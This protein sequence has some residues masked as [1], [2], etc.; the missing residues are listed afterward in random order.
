MSRMLVVLLMSLFFPA[1]TSAA[2]ELPITYT[3][4]SPLVPADE[5]YDV[6]VYQSE[7][8]TVAR[9]GRA[10]REDFYRKATTGKADWSMPGTWIVG[11][12]TGGRMAKMQNLG[13]TVYVTRELASLEEGKTYRHDTHDEIEWQISDLD[14]AFERGAQDKLV[15]GLAA[16]HFVVSVAY[17]Y[18]Q[19]DHSDGDKKTENVAVERHLWFAEAL[20]FSPVQLLPLQLTNNTFAD[21]APERIHEGIYAR[22]EDQLSAHGMLV[23]T[24]LTLSGMTQT[25]E[26]ANLESVQSLDLTT[27]TGFPIVPEAQSGEV[28]GALFL[29]RMLQGNLPEGGDVQLT[30]N[31]PDSGKKE[32]GA[33]ESAFTVSDDG[34]LGVAATFT[35]DKRDEGLMLIMRPWHGLP[36]EGK[37]SV[38]ERRSSDQVRAMSKSELKDYAKHMQVF[39]LIDGEDRLIALSSAKSGHINLSRATAESLKGK[40]KLRMRSVNVG[41]DGSVGEQS[42]KG[43]FEA[44]SGLDVRLHNAVTRRLK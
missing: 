29:S 35:L 33:G 8:M 32:K 31:G 15:A 20:P 42:M 28:I 4:N 9:Q 23:R 22:L 13:R 10:D 25:L 19:I 6:R 21:F 11:D 5:P 40:F 3:I 39:A 17:T 44:V 38:V 1:I 7:D 37:H 43:S 36:G 12:K 14:I 27:L 18:Q 41:E 24:Q 16:K 34:D 2:P 30:L 26:V